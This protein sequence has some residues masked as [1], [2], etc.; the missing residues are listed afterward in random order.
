MINCCRYNNYTVPL[1]HQYKGKRLI[2]L[3]ADAL[4]IWTNWG[5]QN[6]ITPLLPFLLHS[7]SGI[8]TWMRLNIFL[9]AL[10]KSLFRPN[11]SPHTSSCWH[12]PE[13]EVDHW[14]NTK[15]SQRSCCKCSYLSWQRF[16]RIWNDGKFWAPWAF[17]LH[18]PCDLTEASLTH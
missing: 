6:Q 12:T 15:L 3:E 7:T 13:A 4:R 14:V 16:S 1:V 17:L 2:L 10:Q 9:L 18:R 5:S 8:T 11:L